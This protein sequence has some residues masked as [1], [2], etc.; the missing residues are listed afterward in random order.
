MVQDGPEVKRNFMENMTHV[1]Q[2]FMLTLYKIKTLQIMYGQ[3][4]IYQILN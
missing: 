1:K 2:D 4:K 3:H